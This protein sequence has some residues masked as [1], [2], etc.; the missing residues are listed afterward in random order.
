MGRLP[1]LTVKAFADFELHEAEEWLAGRIVDIT[2]T[3]DT[4]F[5][6]G[7]KYILVLDDDEPN[8]DGSD[9][10]VW[11]FSSQ[12]VSRKSKLGKW[13][14]AVLLDE[15]PEEGDALDLNILLQV[16][17]EVMFEQ[18]EGQDSDG[19]KVTKEKVIKMRAKKKAA[20]KG[21]AKAAVVEDDD[22]DDDEDDGFTDLQRKQKAAKAA[23]SA[24]PTETVEPF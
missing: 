4:G 17:L 12:K 9:R 13:A 10:E 1:K 6:V 22:E 19:N 21:R 20:P 23:R 14:A 15:Y 8:D 3:D 5:G 7:L 24:T 11:A 2:E 18:F 16:P